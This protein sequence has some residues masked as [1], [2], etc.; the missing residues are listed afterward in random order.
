M[1]PDFVN[2]HEFDQRWSALDLG[3]DEYKQLQET[4]LANIKAGPV[5]P[6][7]GKLR[8][9][10]FPYFGRGKRGGLRVMS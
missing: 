10:R 2:T 6:G 4:L 5:I 8:K 7:T 1:L 3:D 9:L